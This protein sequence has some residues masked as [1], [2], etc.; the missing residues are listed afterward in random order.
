MHTVPF[1]RYEST[2]PSG[3]R[4]MKNAWGHVARHCVASNVK[5]YEAYA[6]EHNTESPSR[7]THGTSLGNERDKHVSVTGPPVEGQRR[8]RSE[9]DAPFYLFPRATPR[10]R[11]Y[12]TYFPENFRSLLNRTVCRILFYTCPLA[13][14]HRLRSHGRYAC[15]YFEWSLD[16]LFL[17]F[18]AFTE[19]YWVFRVFDNFL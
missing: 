9:F 17:L 19:R 7:V 3:W 14:S 4:G 13:R 5:P 2:S 12:R 16:D 11:R 1:G 8:E 18:L 10:T 15:S 6:R